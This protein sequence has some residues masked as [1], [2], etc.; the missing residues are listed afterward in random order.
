MTTRSKEESPGF[1][2]YKGWKPSAK[3][4][5]PLIDPIQASSAKLVAA[6]AWTGE[7]ICRPFRGKGRYALVKVTAPSSLEYSANGARNTRTAA[8]PNLGPGNFLAIKVLC[9]HGSST[10]LHRPLHRFFM[11]GIDLI[12]QLHTINIREPSE[13]A[14]TAS[15]G[16]TTSGQ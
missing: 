13:A 16:K 14:R 1:I 2:W 4:G 3:L 15:Y 8:I 6:F 12:I 7:A 11:S 5:P 9:S 10:A